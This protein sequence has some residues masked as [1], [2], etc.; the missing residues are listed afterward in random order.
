[1]IIDTHCHIMNEDRMST[2]RAQTSWAE[3]F[4]VEETKKGNPTTA[5]HILSTS[6][7]QWVDKDGSKTIAIMDKSRIDKSFLLG[8]VTDFDKEDAEGPYR[9]RNESL[10]KIARRYPDR[11]VFFGAL[12]PV[13]KNSAQVLEQTIKKWGVKGIKLDPI[14]GEYNAD[15]RTIYRTYE[16]LQEANMP[17]VMHCGPRPEDPRLRGSHPEIIDKVLADFP[18]L[19]IIAAHMGF[20]WWRELIEVGKKRPH[21][22]CDISANQLS[23]A[24]YFERFCHILRKVLDGFGSERVMFGTDGPYFDYFI[25]RPDWVKLIGELPEKSSASTRFT[26]KE[27]TN[28]LGENARR[29]LAE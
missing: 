19:T 13:A 22:H 14:G 25:S 6:F 7:T 15:D 10:S 26:K 4:A 21:L 9:E 28:I 11:F 5:E 20:A 17:V 24:L 3:M 12:Y 27:V 18:E 23:A 8:E 2:A 29:L 16:I 1:M